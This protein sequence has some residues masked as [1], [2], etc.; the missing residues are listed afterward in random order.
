MCRALY[1]CNVNLEWYRESEG[2]CT[3][4]LMPSLYSLSTTGPLFWFNTR[5]ER[6]KALHKAIELCIKKREL[7]WLKMVWEEFD[8]LEGVCCTLYDL[9]VDFRHYLVK[10][11]GGNESGLHQKWV[12]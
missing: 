1:E 3:K 9:G 10:D 7:I 5:E 2:V 6:M 12:D 4:M 8:P 11:W